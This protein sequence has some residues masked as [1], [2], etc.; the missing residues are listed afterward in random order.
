MTILEP[1]DLEAPAAGPRRPGD[2]RDPGGPAGDRGRPPRRWTING[3]FLALAPT[4]VARYARE[5]ATALDLLV[6]EGHALTRDLDLDVVAP[7][8]GREPLAL[9]ALA[10][11]IVPEFA[12]PRLPQVWVQLQL[13]RH[14][15]GGLLSFCNL[16]PVAPRRHIACI[17]DL[18][19][20]LTPE[21]YGR[22]FGLAH[23]AILPA[24]GRRAAA[25]TT[26]SEFSRGHLAQFGVAPAE[27]ITVTYNGSDHA[28]RWDPARGVLPAPRRPYALCLGR[29][30]KHKNLDLLLRLAPLLDARGLD[31]WMAGEVDAASLPAPPDNLV[32]LGRI[33][34]DDFAQA[35]AGARAFLLPSRIEGF[36]LPAVEAMALRCPVVASTA[37]CLPEICGPAALYA[38]PDDPEAWI[39]AVERLAD[40]LARRRVVEAGAACA[41]RYSW[42]RI[43]EQ[44]LELMARVDAA[45]SLGRRR[46]PGWRR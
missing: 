31:L 6:A 37:P 8:R 26:V 35:L 21:S 24:L 13:P 4:G 42:R 46:S 15:P 2:A 14:V 38:D 20:R 23:R 18:Q 10:L 22:L 28:R 45:D 17:H 41:R 7:T 34:D 43:A 29:G 5:V 32:L 33:G 3:D 19:T 40:P 30:Q 16:A 36:G 44:Y 39:A 25:I 9:R 11:R 1:P 12:R 27:K